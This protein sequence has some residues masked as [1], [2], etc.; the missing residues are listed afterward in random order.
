[1]ATNA[2]L[3]KIYQRPYIKSKTIAANNAN[4][5]TYTDS[6]S[7]F[8]K[9]GFADD[10][11]ITVS[12]FTTS[13][14]NGSKTIDTVVAGT[15]TLVGGDTLTDEVA[16]DEVTI[17]KDAPGNLIAAA[18]GCTVSQEGGVANI[19]TFADSIKCTKTAST[20]SF[21]D[22]GTSADEIRDSGNG[23]VTAGFEA[24]DQIWVT[25]SSL[26]NYPTLVTVLSVSA[27]SMTVPSGTVTAE[28][29][30]ETVTIR[31]I[32]FWLKKKATSKNWTATIDRLWMASDQ[33]LF[34]VPRSYE[35]FMKYYDTPS[36]GSVAYYLEGI[37]IANGI[38]TDMPLYEIVKGPITIEGVGALTVKSK[39]TSW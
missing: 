1:M 29:A 16:G 35:F 4:P 31:A 18:S 14:N 19:S 37:G 26:N 38:T 3:A 2:I 5:D 36:G 25:G 8:V 22:N 21:V 11:E 15:I 6:E 23:L 32:N 39:S 13:G 10:D 24:G 9:A 34:Q 17:I 33:Q 20:I 12:G 7:N 30:G 28:S 27:G